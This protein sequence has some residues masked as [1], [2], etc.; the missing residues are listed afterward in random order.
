[1]PIETGVSAVPSLSL[2]IIVFASPR[3]PDILAAKR[4]IL[5]LHGSGSWTTAGHVN[6]LGPTGSFRLKAQL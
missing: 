1:M 6:R 2:I 5:F 3:S 4:L